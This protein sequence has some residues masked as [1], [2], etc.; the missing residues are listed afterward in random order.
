MTRPRIAVLGSA[1]MDLVVTTQRA[2]ERG[3]T[4]T[5]H[6]FRTVP[7]G[8]GANQALAAARAGGDVTFLGAV[9]DDDFGRRI[10]DLLEADGID[11]GELAVVA[12]TTG[13]AHITVDD[14]G[15]NSIV[16][17]PGA[18]G[19]VTALTD[20]HRAAIRAADAL[21]LQLELPL[22]VV[23]EA[24]A[25]AHSV[26]VRT[27][28]TP[29]PAIPLAGSLL[30]QVDFLVPNEH[31]AM[32]LTGAD[33]PHQAGRELAERCA[34][35]VVTLGAEGAVYLG[36]GRPAL[37]VPAFP[38]EVLDTTA[39]GDT[40][41]GVLAVGLAEGLEPEATLRRAAAASALSV[42][43]FGASSSMPTRTEIDHF[44]SR[45]ESFGTWME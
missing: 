14:T 7:G 19:C 44:L 12:E 37:Q 3:E 41:V 35:V 30:E 39:A 4:V 36:S 33:D 6:E 43:R 23:A 9:G 24:A 22:L 13:T 15:D 28:L 26:G 5:G 8:K 11:V 10:R 42:Q 18:N 45:W 2:P 20:P 38:V 21:L 32:I 17:V 25:Y 29:A 34:Q 31:E 1:N 27:V 16:V 40:F